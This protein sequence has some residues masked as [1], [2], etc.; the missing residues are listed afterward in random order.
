MPVPQRFAAI[1]MCI[2]Y[3]VGTAT[4]PPSKSSGIDF[5]HALKMGG[6]TGVF[7]SIGFAIGSMFA[8]TRRQSD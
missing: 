1:F 6:F 5:G 8:G 4:L 3:A 2:G 7:G